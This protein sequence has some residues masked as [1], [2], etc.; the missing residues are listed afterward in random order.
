MKFAIYGAGAIGAYLGAKLSLAGEDVALIARGPHLAAM[1]ERGVVVRSPDGDFTAN[2]FATNDAAEVGVADVVVLAVK[3]H[4]LIPIAPLLPPLIGPDTVVLPAQNGI[5]WWYFQRHGGSWEGTRL[6][7]V[8]PGG[9]ITEHVPAENIVG[10][11]VYP[12]ATIVEPGVIEHEEG[13]RFSLGRAGRDH[14]GAGQGDLG[15]HQLGAGLRA[16]VRGNIR[17]EIW[18]KLLGN[19]AFNPISALTQAGMAEIAQDPDAGELARAMMGEAYSVATALGVE[20]P[21]GIDQRMAGAEKVGDHKTSMLQD[22]ELARPI[23]I[24][25]L[26][27]VVL[28]LG[29]SWACRCRARRR[30]TR[31]PSCSA[32]RRSR[33]RGVRGRGRAVPPCFGLVHW[34]QTRTLEGTA[35]WSMRTTG[36]RRGSSWPRPTGSLPPGTACR[37]RRSCGARRRT[38]LW[39]PPLSGTGRAGATGSS[40]TPSPNLRRSPTTSFC[41]PP[42]AS[43][44]SFIETSTTTKW[45]TM[46]SGMIGRWS[47]TS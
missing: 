14:V 40:R 11:V 25:G 22:V 45:R 20:I 13:N 18:V 3:A 12:A 34:R 19:L 47:I 42:L 46:K 1:R 44:R 37:H 41:K 21:I 24:G 43:R 31:A 4:G 26:V 6:E 36:K 32:R 33:R 7:S 17:Q 39:P 38:R 28:E 2:V 9:V 27:G 35:P 8:D 23:E 5:P 10:C 30:C 29:G 15:G 16:P